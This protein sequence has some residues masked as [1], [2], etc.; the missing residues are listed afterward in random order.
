M[1]FHF[2]QLY[3]KPCFTGE[4]PVSVVTGVTCSDVVAVPHLLAILKDA[5]K[6]QLLETLPVNISLIH[7]ASLQP[8][9]SPE[10]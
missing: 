1:I 8:Q 5:F 6:P 4:N 10:L 7:H 3:L 9:I 2:I